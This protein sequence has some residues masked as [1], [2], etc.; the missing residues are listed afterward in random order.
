VGGGGR[1]QAVTLH[2]NQYSVMCV[3][4]FQMPR[5]ISTIEPAKSI[6]G[7]YIYLFQGITV[8]LNNLVA[9]LGG[10]RQKKKNN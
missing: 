3:K 6:S 5:V 4:T 7:K 10:N 9:S 2:L 8:H 1:P